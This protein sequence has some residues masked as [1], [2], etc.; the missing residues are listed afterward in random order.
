MDERTQG[1]KDYLRRGQVVECG[2]GN[3]DLIRNLQSEICNLEE[4]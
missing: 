3:S 2:F 1:A 4:E